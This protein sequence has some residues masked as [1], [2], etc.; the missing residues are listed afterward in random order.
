MVSSRGFSKIA[1]G[2][3]LFF[4]YAPAGTRERRVHFHEFMLEVHKRLYQWAQHRKGDPV[5][6]VAAE[7]AADSQ[8]LCFDESQA[9][10]VADS[11]LMKRL[12]E[13]LWSRGCVVA[14][15]NT[16]HDAH[17]MLL[18][19]VA[20][21]NREP[22]RLY[23]NGINRQHFVPFI[24]LLKH[25]CEIIDLERG[26][27]A[28][29]SDYRRLMS[30]SSTHQRF[31]H[32]QPHSLESTVRDLVQDD[33]EQNVSV[34]VMMGRTL[35]L[36]KAFPKAGVV[37][38][39]FGELCDS[40]V[41]PADYL[42]LARGFGTVVLEG[43]PVMGPQQHNEARRFISLLDVLYENN[44]RTIISAA[45]PPDGLFEGWD[46]NKL[47]VGKTCKTAQCLTCESFVVGAGVRLEGRS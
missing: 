47:K 29:A 28:P 11:M 24:G 46:N 3:I 35:G 19:V 25:H 8:L 13:Q 40:A 22:D 20:T 18:Q 4:A 21:S 44:N 38:C 36:S 12:F 39:S 9:T 23:E 34:P 15:S 41:G 45:A 17:C 32:N 31:F 33:P 2:L 5:P 43:V 30:V 27:G 1:V 10:D 42:A 7:V 16:I 14:A 37:R 26:A 6:G